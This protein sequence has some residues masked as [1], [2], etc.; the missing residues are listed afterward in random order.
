MLRRTFL[1]SA[2]AAAA[3]A[4]LAGAGAAIAATSKGT[5]GKQPPHGFTHVTAPTQYV[6]ANGIRFAYRRFGKGNGLPLVFTQ[7]FL[8]NMDNWDPAV[9][10]GFAAEREVILFDNTG[11]ASTSGQVPN[12][13]GQMG[14]DAG[15]FIQAL[16]LKKIDLLGF[17]MGGLVAQQIA[18]DHPDLVR[19]LVLTGTGPRSGVHMATQTP[20]SEA[21]FS[22]KYPSIDDMWLAVFFTK[23]DASQTAGHAFIKRY[24][25]RQVNRDTPMSS[26]VEPAQIAALSTSGAPRPDPYAYLSD[27]GQPTLVVNGGKDVIIYPINSFVLQQN[28]PNAK[29]ILYPD[30]GHGSLFQYP[31]QYVRD[32]S[33][34]LNT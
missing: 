34:F 26:Q 25:E 29:L 31:D 28:L 16:G 17:S 3:T 4:S 15:A 12:T 30:A 23:S 19:R 18:L 32:V 2:G 20:E 22:A 14:K 10:D 7:H 1:K 9:T 11:V 24:R 6:E 21:I 33:A 27:I 13:I 5:P 8:G